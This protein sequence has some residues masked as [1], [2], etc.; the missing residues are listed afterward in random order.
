MSDYRHDIEKYIKGEL[1]PAERNALERKALHDPFLADALEGAEGIKATDFTQDVAELNAKITG[2]RKTTWSLPLRIAAGLALVGVSTFLVWNVLNSEEIQ[3]QELALEKSQSAPAPSITDSVAS[4]EDVFPQPKTQPTLTPPPGDRDVAS[5]SAGPSKAESKPQETIADL[6]NEPAPVVAE[7]QIA[8][9]KKE[10]ADEL[11]V[12][13]SIAQAEAADTAAKAIATD[14]VEKERLAKTDARKKSLYKDA[15]PA[16]SESRA[17]GFVSSPSNIIR[18]QVTSAEDGSPLPGVNVI[19]KNSVTGTA[20]DANGNY[21]IATEQTNPTLVY[22]FIGLNSKEIKAE[23]QQ[24]DVQMTPDNAQ[25]S[26]VVVT[27]Y[28]TQKGESVPPTVEFAHPENGNRAFKQYLEK[29]ISYPEQA[30]TNKTE[31]RVTVEF[32]IQSDGTL[33]DFTVVRG[34]GSG[35]DEELIRLIKEGPRWIPT[36]KD[37]VPV[38]DK[39]KV[40]LK[41]ELPE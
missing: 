18:G 12:A 30:L 11:K 24:V 2:G 37:N 1:T 7:E 8:K 32:T 38:Q 41:F 28:G 4:G 3:P 29:N 14:D 31:G 27:G 15:A 25:L 33:S 5:R 34:I 16:A 9:A 13:E 39:A 17:S 21:Q 35:C 26:E 40:R 22:S 19:I 10:K 36:K 20:T 23:Q 6:K